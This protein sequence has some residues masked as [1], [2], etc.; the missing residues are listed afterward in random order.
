M[1]NYILTSRGFE[2]GN[3][4]WFFIFGMASFYII[5]NSNLSSIFQN[6]LFL[7]V[8]LL[9][10]F[11]YLFFGKYLGLG[12]YVDDVNHYL[13]NNLIPSFF[14]VTSILLLEKSH[15]DF[16]NKILILLGNASYSIYLT[17]YILI[18]SVHDYYSKDFS[19]LL[20]FIGSII[21]GV[22]TYLYLELPMT[23]YTHKFIKKER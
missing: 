10:S 17:H 20:L 19:N 21:L 4:F 7:L 18:H 15:I 8:V 23:K 5:K 16:D 6:K 11:I 9:S 14:I 1:L 3:Y 2:Y 13:Y 22:L 12:Y